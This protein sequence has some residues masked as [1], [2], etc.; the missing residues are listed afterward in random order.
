[1]LYITVL[2]DIF[3]RKPSLLFGEYAYLI[4]GIG[5]YWLG[6]FMKDTLRENEISYSMVMTCFIIIIIP[7]TGL[8]NGFTPERTVYFLKLI[9]IPYFILLLKDLN[10][11][12][13]NQT[14]ILL[15]IIPILYLQFFGYYLELSHALVHIYPLDTFKKDL[16]DRGVLEFFSSNVSTDS[17]VL[18]L[19]GIKDTYD[20]HH[21]IAKMIP[22][23]TG[24]RV[25][26]SKYDLMY[27]DDEAGGI[28]SEPIKRQYN[29]PFLEEGTILDHKLITVMLY[30][31]YE[32]QEYKN[33]IK[34]DYVIVMLNDYRYIFRNY[35]QQI[36]T[37]DYY[38]V[39]LVNSK[40][41]SQ[42]TDI[43][44]ED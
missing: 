18:T 5:F 22:F 9:L 19:P 23:Y 34:K 4:W 40:V 32:L 20:G 16:R 6:I 31:P 33:Q 25:F 41:I 12:T 42:L 30:K 21:I 13:D 37:D 1:M 14:A 26:Y 38:T 28:S 36:Y 10:E 29:M 2:F 11:R 43:E 8:F 27:W 39:Y 15:M 3:I 44:N 7:L 35:Y 17:I 24:H